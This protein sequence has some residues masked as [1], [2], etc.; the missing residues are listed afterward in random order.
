M[1][2]VHDIEVEDGTNDEALRFLVSVLLGTL[3]SVNPEF[4]TATV[5]NA[6]GFKVF[7]WC[8]Q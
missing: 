7:K 4:V 5:S 2:K 3:V 8:S 6:P 1:E